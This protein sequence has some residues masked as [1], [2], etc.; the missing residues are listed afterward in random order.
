MATP[1]ERLIDQT[2]T[3]RRC[4]ATAAEGCDCM[5]ARKCAFKG[6][7]NT[8]TVCG[9]VE[10]VGVVHACSKHSKEPDFTPTKE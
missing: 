5:P 8:A 2:A 1:L 10:H 6:C 9:T 3:C 4:G 7:G